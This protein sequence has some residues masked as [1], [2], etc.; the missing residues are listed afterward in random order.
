M[1]RQLIE[2][3]G[4]FQVYE[5]VGDIPATPKFESKDELISHLTSEGTELDEP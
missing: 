2:E 4:F 1:G 5:T 3:D